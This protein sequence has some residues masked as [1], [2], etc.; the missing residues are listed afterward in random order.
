MAT[1]TAATAGECFERPGF[2]RQTASDRPGI[3]QPVP[4]RDVPE[5]PWRRVLAGAVVGA[6]LLLGGW[7]WYWR[8]W[9]PAPAYLNSAGAWAEQR[10]RIDAGEGDATVLV[11]TSRVLFDVQLPVWERI[12]G[13]RPIQLAL[14]GTSPLPVLEDLAADPDFTGRVLVDATPDLFFSGYTYRGEAVRHYHE[15]G[16]SQRIGHWLSK[17]LIEGRLAFYDPDFALPTVVHRQAWPARPGVH[18]RMQV[19][20]LMVMEADRNTRLWPRVEHDAEY[21][22]LAQSIWAQDFGGPLPGMD[23]PEKKRAGIEAQLARAVAAVKRLETR[24]VSVV[25]VR[26]P[27]DGDYYAY[28]QRHL[29]RAETWELLLTRTGR[30]GIHFEDHAAMQSLDLPEWSHLSA[31]DAQRYTEVLAT[32]IQRARLWDVA[33]ASRKAPGEALTEASAAPAVATR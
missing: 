4:Q 14:E 30:P 6:A 5:H 28:E 2:V 12:T 31:R 26:P 8:A 33:F 27:S 32:E 15:R 9:D 17:H 20:K 29:P 21:R 24:G 1:D 3:A 7:E 13:E 19:R 22:A 16:P 10:A 11:G 25:F 23:T 18:S